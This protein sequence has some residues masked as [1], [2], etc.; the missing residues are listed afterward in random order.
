MYGAKKNGKRKDLPAL[1]K[2][3]ILNKIGINRFT[4][5]EIGKQNKKV[6]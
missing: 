6:K 4:L 5:Y 3:Q 2:K 1:D